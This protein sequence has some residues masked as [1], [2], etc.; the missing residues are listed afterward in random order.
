MYLRGGKLNMK[1][2]R[3]R[4]SNPFWLAFLVMAIGGLIYFNQVVIPEMPSPFMPSPTPTRSQE[5]LLNEAGAYLTEGKLS[6]AIEAYQQAVLA[7]PRNPSTFIELA[8]IQI[9]AG[10]DEQ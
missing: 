5:S 7:D 8:R 1:K 9:F 6:Q 4:P 2:R 3:R 10:L